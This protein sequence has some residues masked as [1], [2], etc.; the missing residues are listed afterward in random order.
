LLVVGENAISVAEAAKDFL[1]V[2]E[3]VESHGEVATIMRDG[4]PIARLVPLSRPA[5]SCEELAERWKGMSKLPPDEA[6]AFARDLES[7]RTTV[8]PLKSRWD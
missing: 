7:V 5:A 8:P 1:R 4:Q 6:E 2:L 3:R